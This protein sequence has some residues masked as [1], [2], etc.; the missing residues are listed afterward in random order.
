MFIKKGNKKF[1]P[2]SGKSLSLHRKRQFIIAANP[3]T[4]AQSAIS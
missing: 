2:S 1:K 4:L 3:A